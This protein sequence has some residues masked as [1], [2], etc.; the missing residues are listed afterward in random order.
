MIFFTN[1]SENCALGNLYQHN[2]SKLYTSYRVSP[3]QINDYV[4]IMTGPLVQMTE[5]YCMYYEIIYNIIVLN[6][7]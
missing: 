7:Y 4:A 2:P 1:H 5:A 3:P 6:P